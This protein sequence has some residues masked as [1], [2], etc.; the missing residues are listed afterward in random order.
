[1]LEGTI[2]PGGDSSAGVGAAVAKTASSFDGVTPTGAC[3]GSSDCDAM[4]LFGALV[5]MAEDV[6]AFTFAA[7]LGAVVR[8]ASLGVVGGAPDAASCRGDEVPDSGP[9]KSQFAV[10][11]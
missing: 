10:Q 6:G 7:A 9:K 4:T 11:F 8:S 3:E 2:G 1:M 5:V